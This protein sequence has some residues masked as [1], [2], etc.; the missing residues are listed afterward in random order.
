MHTIRRR[1]NFGVWSDGRARTLPR[2]ASRRCSCRCSVPRRCDR[3]VWATFCVAAVITCQVD[4]W[5]SGRGRRGLR[6]GPLR[7]SSR[8][9]WR[10]FRRC[11]WRCL[12]L[13][14]G[15]LPCRQ[16]I[17]HAA[18]PY[19][20]S[21]FRCKDLFAD[22]RRKCHM[23]Q[24]EKI[25]N[26]STIAAGTRPTACTCI[27]VWHAV[28]MRQTCMTT[29]AH[30]PLIEP[31]RQSNHPWHGSHASDNTIAKHNVAR[32]VEAPPR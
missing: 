16:L 18:H 10:A 1:P 9:S 27:H 8:P 19:S 5:R 2:R 22:R 24:Q 21:P 3:G 14:L 6:C 30:H 26:D 32:M 17:L 23:G 29:E 25:C 20:S 31:Q 11:L 28:C 7:C 12:R 15:R 13:G 4:G